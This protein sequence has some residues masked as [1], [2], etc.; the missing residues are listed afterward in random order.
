[1]IKLKNL[2][3]LLISLCLL[4]SCQD[5]IY[6]NDN[7]EKEKE[8]EEDNRELITFS[9][10][11]EY[12]DTLN[13]LK[14]LNLSE[15]KSWSRSRMDKSYFDL[16][17]FPDSTLTYL[18]YEVRATLNSDLEFK[19]NDSILWYNHHLIYYLTDQDCSRKELDRLKSDPTKLSWIL[20]FGVGDQDQN[21]K[22]RILSK[23]SYT[24]EIGEL[25]MT[26]NS[27]QSSMM[28]ATEPNYRGGRDIKFAAVF[29]LH[30]NYEWVKVP[31]SRHNWSQIIEGL[32]DIKM[33]EL[34]NGV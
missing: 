16:S 12:Y 25:K 33:Y 15:L 20:N 17:Y 29:G 27:N 31:G 4:I 19:V 11:L 22:S 13:E 30:C 9:S 26:L 7:Q 21:P 3:P 8:K 18:P 24:K 2:F 10:M 5:D 32:V 23:E 1:M 6:I 28:R 14:E 34:I